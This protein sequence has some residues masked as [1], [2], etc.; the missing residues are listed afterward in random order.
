MRLD[1]GF[2][3]L[4]LR[5]AGVIMAGLVVLN[6]WVPR[7]FHW[8]EELARL[9][10]L[11]RQIF[12]AHSMFIVLTLGLFAALLLLYGPE[13]LQ[14]TPLARAI[15]AG[16]TIFWSLRML[17]QWFFYSPAIWRGDRQLTVMHAL[18]SVTWVYVSIVFASALWLNCSRS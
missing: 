6:L 10:L 1:G 17:T 2:V 5:L 8:R 11:N 18:F 16:L 13:L 15:L 7:R 12:Q 4:N 14:P 9:S 3:L